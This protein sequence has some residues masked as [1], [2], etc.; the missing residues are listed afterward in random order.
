MIFN[1]S[2]DQEIKCKGRS[3][4]FET[5]S[6]QEMDILEQSKLVI[7]YKKGEVIA[8]QGASNSDVIYLQEGYVKLY[9]EY[10]N[11]RS[12]SLIEQKCNFIGLYG[13]FVETTMQYTL[14]ALTDVVVCSFSKNLFESLMKKNNSFALEI[15]KKLNTKTLN[16]FN[17]LFNSSS[18]QMHGRLAWALL[19]LTQNV[20]MDNA[21]KAPVT[22][23]DLAEFTNM[24]VM[25]VGRIL[26]E[27]AEEKLIELNKDH[28]K[29]LEKD[30]LII[31]CKNG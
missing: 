20:F 12:L 14:V 30:K 5:L 28:I 17:N 2:N 21:L 22:R 15:I 23:K 31:T 10:S 13:L 9:K 19:E 8:K 18:K 7:H 3:K 27:F 26:R 4:C 1:A 6:G 25:S 11:T 16:T 29:I 24:S